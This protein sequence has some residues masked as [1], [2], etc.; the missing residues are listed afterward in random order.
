MPDVG[1]GG[2]TR[3]P[4]NAQIPNPKSKKAP[5]VKMGQTEGRKYGTDAHKKTSK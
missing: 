4:G 5:I 3:G 1:S 2:K